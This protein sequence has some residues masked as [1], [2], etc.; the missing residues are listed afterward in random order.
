MN[1]IATYNQLII[2]AGFSGLCA[3]IKLK[4]A[5]EN[6]FLIL[7]RN[8]NLGGTWYDNHYPGAAC[9]IESHLYSYSF[10]PNPNRSMQFSPQ[11]EILKYMEHCA[12]KYELLPHI[13]FNSNITRAIFDD[14][15]GIWQ[16]ETEA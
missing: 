14:N 4:E 15:N 12:K 16:V 1:N 7:E 10:E 6:N 9:D 8:D 3:A 5:G 13:Q 11:E 2:G